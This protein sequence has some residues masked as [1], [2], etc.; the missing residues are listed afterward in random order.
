VS[1]THEGLFFSGGMWK[2]NL[3]LKASKSA[4]QMYKIPCTPENV[5]WVVNKL[6]RTPGHYGHRL[7][8]SRQV[9]TR[10]LLVWCHKCG[11]FSEGKRLVNLAEKCQPIVIGGPQTFGKSA[12]KLLERLLH[13]VNRSRLEIPWHI[14]ETQEYITAIQED[15]DNP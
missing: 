3:C 6:L 10:Q 9:E 15:A 8:C 7:L 2:C 11:S 13:P 1:N 14:D 4:K 5:P 12:I